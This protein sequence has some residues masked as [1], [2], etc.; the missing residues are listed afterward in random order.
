MRNK[1]YATLDELEKTY[2]KELDKIRVT[3]QTSLTKDVNNC[4]R[5]EDELQQLHEA[6]KSLSEN[7]K[8]EM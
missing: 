8:T 3:L 7:S 4:S 2:L 5:L 6:V 1:L